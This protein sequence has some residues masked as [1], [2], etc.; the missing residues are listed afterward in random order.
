[1]QEA[2]SGRR[3]VLT[4]RDESS[5]RKMLALL[6]RQFGGLSDPSHEPKGPL[7]K[8]TRESFDSVLLNLR[9]S[10]SLSEERLSGVH[11]IRASIVGRVLVVTG[12]IRDRHTMELVERICVPHAGSWSAVRALV[13][14]PDSPDLIL[15]ELS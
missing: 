15:D 12:E 14:V 4:L 6:S 10:V 11:K 13:G 5:I 9:C 8:F 1:M 2:T 7:A 3:R